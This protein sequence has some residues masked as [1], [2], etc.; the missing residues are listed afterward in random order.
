MEVI[1][2]VYFRKKCSVN[3]ELLQSKASKMVAFGVTKID[4]AIQDEYGREFRKAMQAI[5]CKYDYDYA[6]DATSV[7]FILKELA[8]AD[9]VRNLRDAPDVNALS[10]RKAANAVG[11]S[12]LYLQKLIH[13]DSSAY[14][15]S[16][17][18]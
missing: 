16:A 18:S 2:Y 12:V 7:T 1:T 15:A 9:G 14:S 3:V 11:K 10:Q 17:D 5:C 6:H 4:L 8:G 13:N